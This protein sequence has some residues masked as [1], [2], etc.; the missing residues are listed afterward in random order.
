MQDPRRVLKELEQRARRRF[1]QHFLTRSSLAKRMVQA[2]RVEAGQRVLEIGPG[3]GMLSGALMEAGVE[4]TL[5]ELDRDLAAFLREEL[6][7]VAIHQGDALKMDLEELCPGQGWKVVANL[8]YNVGTHLVMRLLRAVPKFSALT[9]MLQR[10]LIQRFI[11]EPGS[12]TYGALSVQLQVRCRPVFLF[13]VPPTA[14][15]PPPKVHS[16]VVRMEVFGQPD[17]GVGGA[18]AFDKVVQAGFSQRRKMLSNSLGATFG[19]QRALDALD[20]AGL[21]PTLRAEALSVA[22]FRALSDA[23]YGA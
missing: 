6:P 21:P 8:P 7:D 20:G 17:F 15:H 3:L 10:E 22:Q 1:G 13:T 11:A 9:V 12:K 5:C 2:S 14:F 23:L 4:L 19:K 18:A 16:A